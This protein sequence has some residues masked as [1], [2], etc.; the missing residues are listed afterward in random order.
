VTVRSE[1]VLGLLHVEDLVHGVGLGA[2]RS[3][4]YE[5][6]R[7]RETATM[8]KKRPQARDNATGV[9]LR[10]LPAATVELTLKGGLFAGVPVGH[11]GHGAADDLARHPAARAHRG[12]RHSDR[13]PP[14]RRRAGAHRRSVAAESPRSRRRVRASRALGLQVLGSGRGERHA[15]GARRPGAGQRRGVLGHVAPRGAASGRPRAAARGRKVVPRRGHALRGF[16]PS[17]RVH[18]PFWD[19]PSG[20]TAGDVEKPAAEFADA[21]LTA[22]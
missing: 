4:P 2:G 3:H 1:F 14:S 6:S 12:P 18:R 7:N 22:A 21:P 5:T 15:G 11:A 9:A 13:R 8:A 16:L 19:L 10:E 20:V 17:P